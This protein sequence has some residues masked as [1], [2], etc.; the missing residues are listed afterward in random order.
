[1]S[2]LTRR[3]LLIAGG[4][5]ALT[6]CDQLASND[7]LK[8]I[9]AS[10]EDA[11]YRWQ[12]LVGRDSLARE[13]SAADI[14]PVFKVNGTKAPVEPE[15]L[16]MA[17]NGFA[18]WKLTIR[19]LVNNPMALSLAELKR[20]PARTQI[21]RHD[22]VEGWSAIGQWTGPQLGGLLKA[23]GLKPNARYVVFTCADNYGGEPDKGGMQSKSRY[24][25]SID[26]V[27]AFHPQT[28][29][30]HTMNGAPLSVGHGAPIRLRVERQLGY[31]QAKYI[32]AIDVVDS[33]AGF[34]SGKGGYWE[35]RGYEWY[36]GI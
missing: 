35:D 10:G 17:G 36:A 12:R 22:C 20:L 1:M 4:G 16:A 18:D 11:T 33:F 34:G 3:S 13:F 19:G 24:Y 30:A 29:L 32:M 15:Y 26:M 8:R 25:E 2:L 6:G 31:K 14:S 5:L 27:D 21:T 23:A 9:M 28:I 7:K